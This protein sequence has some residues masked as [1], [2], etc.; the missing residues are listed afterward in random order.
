[1]E[2]LESLVWA[3]TTG[4]N[5]LKGPLAETVRDA[6]EHVRSYLV[7][8]QEG[9]SPALQL[10]EGNPL[11][12]TKQGVLREELAGSSLGSDPELARLTNALIERLYEVAQ[13]HQATIGVSIED[14]H[15][16]SIV[17]QRIGVTA[18]SGVTAGVQVKTAR[19]AG[20]ITIADVGVDRLGGGSKN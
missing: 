18:S 8:T 12:L 15:A 19:V 2:F 13:E 14:V 20:N 3:L 9:L 16:H 10:L 4:A 6:Y 11:S 7:R 5:M 1:M 17:L